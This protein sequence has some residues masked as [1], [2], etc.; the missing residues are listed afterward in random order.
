MFGTAARS[1]TKTKRSLPT[2]QEL[3]SQQEPVGNQ[4]KTTKN[5]GRWSRFG[6]FRVRTKKTQGS[7][8]MGHTTK[9]RMATAATPRK[10]NPYELR[11]Q[12]LKMEEDKQAK[13]K[14]KFFKWKRRQQQKLDKNNEVLDVSKF[15]RRKVSKETRKKRRINTQEQQT[16]KV[17]QKDIGPTY[18][19]EVEEFF[20]LLPRKA[21]T[22]QFSS[23]V[24]AT[25]I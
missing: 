1:V 12:E 25:K 9:K 8:H 18:I 5:K 16:N 21:P 17:V 4:V 11:D 6:K 13:S 15:L 24:C 23:N 10:I 7:N 14:R 19:S 20:Y 3:S 2:L 22:I